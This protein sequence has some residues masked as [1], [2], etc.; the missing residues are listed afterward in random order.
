M[1]P[2]NIG[3]LMTYNE[4]DIIGEVLQANA[5]HFDAIFAIDGSTD[6]T[7]DII[8]KYDNV[9][10][11][12]F[13]KDLPPGTKINDAVRQ[14]LIDEAQKRYGTEGWFTLLH[15][16]EI[17]VDDPNDTIRRAEKAGADIINW[18]VLNFFIHSSQKDI[19]FDDSRPLQDQ[20]N[21]YHPGGIEV[22]QFKNVP[23]L[24]YQP[25]QIYKVLPHGLKNK[26]LLD[27]PILKHYVDRPVHYSTKRYK[28][29]GVVRDAQTNDAGADD[30]Q[31]KDVLETS[32]KQV[33]RYDGAFDE[34]TPGKR[35]SFLIQWL[36]WHRY[37]AIN[38][39]ILTPLITLIKPL[40]GKENSQ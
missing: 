2:L 39:G 10:H 38:W 29:V 8:R 24:R 35:P 15:G 3:L 27:Y 16:D 28:G 36:R 5:S 17:F 40:F 37:V 4:A 11:L 22:R 12:M 30:R 20:I 19:N 14:F 13:D 26:P 33:R 21:H 1:T 31:F 9:V 18:H 6:A 32:K 34:F 7:P 25:D 23:D